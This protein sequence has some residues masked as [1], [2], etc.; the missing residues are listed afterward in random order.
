MPV[1][2]RHQIADYTLLQSRHFFP[3]K[4]ILTKGINFN[5]NIETNRKGEPKLIGRG[6][7][8]I[9]DTGNETMAYSGVLS[10]PILL[11]AGMQLSRSNRIWVDGLD[12]IDTILGNECS[13]ID[14]ETGKIFRYL[15]QDYDACA[16]QSLAINAESDSDVSVD[17][18]FVSNVE[19][20]FAFSSFRND[21]LTTD[22]NAYLTEMRV[23]RAYDIRVGFQTIEQQLIFQLMTGGN[24]NFNFMIDQ[25]PL[26]GSRIPRNIFTYA[27]Y[28]V[29]GQFSVKDDLQNYANNFIDQYNYDLMMPNFQTYNSIS[30]ESTYP[31]GYEGFSLNFTDIDFT[32]NLRFS[33]DI[34]KSSVSRSIQEG[35]L[36]DQVKFISYNRNV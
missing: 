19:D 31:V 14:E 3:N 12:F 30:L 34:V 5:Q 11:T 17:I 32:T 10:L 1:I 2:A 26:W 21:L 33:T 16:I 8:N 36:S 35:L 9:I 4:Y 25:T 22:L 27:N 28:T 20:V 29:E 6:G 23:A 18:E 24:V 15:N 13:L 7:V